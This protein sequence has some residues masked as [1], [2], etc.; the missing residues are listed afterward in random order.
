[1]KQSRLGAHGWKVSSEE[2]ALGVFGGFATVE[3]T[4]GCKVLG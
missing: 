4:E 1:M 2:K 3:P